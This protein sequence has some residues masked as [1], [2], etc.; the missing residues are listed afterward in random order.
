MGEVIT[1][2]CTMDSCGGA[3]RHRRPQNGNG[4]GKAG[5]RSGVGADGIWR[6][7]MRIDPSCMLQSQS[8][9]P[10]S[11]DALREKRCVRCSDECRLQFAVVISSRID[12]RLLISN[13]VQTV[14]RM[15]C[16]N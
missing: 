15:H 11:S 16:R 14:D 13:A 7:L 8:K 9:H 5:G 3:S 10:D 1:R 2:K 6:V 12:N 4:S